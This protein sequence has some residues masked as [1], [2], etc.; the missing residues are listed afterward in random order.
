[1]V[2][3]GAQTAGEIRGEPFLPTYERFGDRMSGGPEYGYAHVA[4]PR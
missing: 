4:S 1:M 3:E 2:A